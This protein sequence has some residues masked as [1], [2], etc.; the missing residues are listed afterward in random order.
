MQRSSRAVRTCLVL[1]GAALPLA[2]G[3]PADAGDTWTNPFPG[4]RHLHRTGADNLDLRAAVVDLC[5]PGVSVRT[6]GFSERGKKTSTYAQSVGAQ[7]A[8]NGDF[9][10]RS[11]DVA[12]SGS[13]YPPC[14]GKP[15]YRTWGLAAHAGSAWPEEIHRD[16]LAAFGAGRAQI[17]D[18]AEHHPL[19]P[20]MQEGLGGHFSLVLDGKVSTDPRIQPAQCGR[21]PRTAMG[22]SKDRNS[23]ILVVVDGR[24]GYRGANC[25]EVAQLLVELGAD[26]GF[27]LDG[28]GSSTF[29]MKGPGVLNHP[30]DGT[31]RTVGAHLA[32]F[33][34]GSGPAL[35]CDPPWRV[36][37]GAPLPPLRLAGS[38][39]SLG[40]TGPTWLEDALRSPALDG[41]AGWIPSPLTPVSPGDGGHL[42]AAPEDAVAVGL[43]VAATGGGPLGLSACG[44]PADA[45]ISLPDGGT[46][47]RALLA[48]TGSEGLCLSAPAGVSVS[49]SQFGHLVQGAG[50]LLQPVEPVTVLDTRADGGRFSGRLPEGVPVRLPLEELP[51]FPPNAE[52]AALDVRVEDS[53]APGLLWVGPCA[54]ADGGLPAWSG[55]WEGE[56]GGNSVIIP[57]TDGGVCLSAG[58]GPHAR[59]TLSA[60]FV[61]PPPPT[62]VAPDA[63][64]PPTDA[65][66]VAPPESGT[67]V[68]GCGCQ[69]VAGSATAAGWLLLGLR[70][71]RT[72]RRR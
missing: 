71:T 35:H 18:W 26:R 6:T 7:L 62:P 41:G 57:V 36:D 51:G 25:V 49:A 37:P 31:E 67:A 63:G 1:L 42:G 30:S 2:W 4:I 3:L 59:V 58:G 14:V 13:P 45:G 66:T 48:P 47:G 61:P 33:A 27:N 64:D 10:C 9:Y 19:L 12:S 11:V 20:W 53:R 72:R 16:A 65:G 17:Y 5:A 46:F 23:L 21:N 50:L 28:G 22:L 34:T 69:G 15:V 24:N 43:N 29:W 38:P 60:L 40:V 8:V 55:W 70:L 52:A 39:V 54:G 44:Q 68:G 32:V 56:T